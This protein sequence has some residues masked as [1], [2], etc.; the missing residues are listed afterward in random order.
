MAVGNT[1]TAVLC[2]RI[3]TAPDFCHIGEAHTQGAAGTGPGV[4]LGVGSPCSHTKTA[5]HTEKHVVLSPSGARPGFLDVDRAPP[6]ALA[7]PSG[8]N[9][10]AR[11]PGVAWSAGRWRMLPTSELTSQGAQKTEPTSPD[12]CHGWW[13]RVGMS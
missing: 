13:H 2:E 8:Q 4:G 11:M 1:T 12:R 7:P 5:S 9:H 10:G 3:Q 6:A